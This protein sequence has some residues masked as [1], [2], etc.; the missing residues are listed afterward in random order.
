MIFHLPVTS[1]LLPGYHLKMAWSILNFWFV[2]IHISLP[3]IDKTRLVMYIQ[4]PA[5]HL[6]SH[7]VTISSAHPLR[8]FLAISP[9]IK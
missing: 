2:L 4:G 9:K 3:D 1:N 6:S 7:I 5:P 8:D